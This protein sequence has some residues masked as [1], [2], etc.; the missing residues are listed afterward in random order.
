[1][2]ASRVERAVGVGRCTLLTL[3]ARVIVLPASVIASPMTLGGSK[4]RAVGTRIRASEP[5]RRAS[6]R[7][8]STVTGNC[9]V[10]LPARII[11]CLPP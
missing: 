9:H 6:I 3:P 4:L 11:E 2:R 8:T 1:M 10:V 5:V 7:R